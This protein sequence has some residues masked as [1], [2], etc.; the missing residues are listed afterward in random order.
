V[1]ALAIVFL[2]VLLILPQ[3]DPGSALIYS[4]FIIVLYREGLPS[5][6]VW[7]GFV[8]IALFVLTLVLEPQY[9]ILLALLVILIV[10]FKSRLDR[11]ILL[12]SILFALFQVL[13]CP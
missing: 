11:N 4:I 5:W 2:P 6:Y 7:T 12:S 10:Y 8:T 1:Q 9:V 13:S 3:P